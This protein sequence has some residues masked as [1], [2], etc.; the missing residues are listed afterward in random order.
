MSKYAQLP[1]LVII[2]HT[3]I[4]L[5]EDTEHRN[6]KILTDYTVWFLEDELDPAVPVGEIV[7]HSSLSSRNSMSLTQKELFTCEQQGSKVMS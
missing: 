2:F 3:Y 1:S 6:K 5:M 7:S 4:W